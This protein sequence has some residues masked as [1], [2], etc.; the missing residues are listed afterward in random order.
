MPQINEWFHA[1]GQT[2]ELTI[3]SVKVLVLYGLL[4]VAGAYYLLVALKS[5]LSTSKGRRT[6]PPVAME[7]H[8]RAEKDIS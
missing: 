8:E 3:D 7:S 6:Q 4:G 5:M 1:T 2:F